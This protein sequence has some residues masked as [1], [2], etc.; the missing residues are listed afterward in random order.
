MAD[1]PAVPYFS[2]DLIEA[3]P[4]AKVIL[5]E[6]PVEGKFATDSHPMHLLLKVFPSKLE[7]NPKEIH[8]DQTNDIQT[9]SNP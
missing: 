4:D 2:E 7:S 3:F 8:T 5:T 6:R 1:G 9:G